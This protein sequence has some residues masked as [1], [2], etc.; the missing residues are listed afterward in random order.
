MNSTGTESSKTTGATGAGT[1]SS[2]APPVNKGNLKVTTPTDREIVMTRVFDAPRRLVW[3]A[4]T[5]PELLKRWLGVFGGMTMPVCEIDLRPGGSYR[6]VW[7]MPN[8]KEM[9]LSGVFKEVVVN[10]RIVSTET[11]DDPWYEGTALGTV[12]FTE[13]QGKTT[14]TMTVLYDS[15]AIRD[16]VLKSG[17]KE[18]VAVSCDMLEEIL[19]KSLS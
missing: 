14:L 19:T 8:G 1:E 4:Y 18:G 7:L 2:C 12:G 13:S 3:D 15:K 17:M 5:K 11:F 16:S 9:G 10:E 6:Y